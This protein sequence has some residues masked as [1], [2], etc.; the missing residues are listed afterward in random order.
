MAGGAGVAWS[1]R[2][3]ASTA[4]MHLATTWRLPDGRHEAG[5]LQL[6]PGQSVSVRSRVALPTRAHAVVAEPGGTLLVVARRPGD[7]LMRF[8]R[9][10]RVLRKHWIKPDRAFNGH[11]WVA[12]DGRTL[13]TTETDL[14]TAQGLIGVRDAQTLE[15]ID[16]WRTHGMDPHALLRDADGHWMVANGG[17]PTLPET[18]RAKRDLGAMNASL[19]RLHRD[20]GVLMGQWRLDDPRLSLRHLAWN[21]QGMLGVALQGEHDEPQAKAPG[22]G[23]GLV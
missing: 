13:C 3:A 10:G 11:V 1:G 17:I 4:P 12:A 16:E 15:K 5:V 2:G 7:W 9:E 18:G 23:P 21:E 6:Q 19:V 20:T 22:A 8:T 14:D